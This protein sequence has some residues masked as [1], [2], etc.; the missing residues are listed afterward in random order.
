MMGEIP[1]EICW[2]VDRFK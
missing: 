2:A 1:P